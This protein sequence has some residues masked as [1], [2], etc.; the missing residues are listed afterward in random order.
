MSLHRIFSSLAHCSVFVGRLTLAVL[1]VSPMAFHAEAAGAAVVQV[2]ANTGKVDCGTYG[3]GI[4][5]GD[6]V[7]LTGRAR[8]AIS[9]SN[10]RGSA[11]SPIV[12][13]N[14]VSESGPL[15]VSQSGDGFLSQCVD[16][17]NVVIDGTGK[18]AGAPAGA[19][20]A[21]LEDGEW[22]LGTRQCGIVF[23]CTSGSPQS[24]LRLG[25]DSKFVIIKGV[26]VDGNLPTCN[27]GI[28]IS[29]N[30]HKYVGKG[31]RVARRY[32]TAQ[33]LRT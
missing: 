7:I 18:W 21:A 4:R 2:P 5:P 20:G 25:G 29:V 26:E 13:R 19:C 6:T 14:D 12:I 30:D 11:S 8:G 23:K 32:S 9:F 3:G 31:W 10:C 1:F 24:S 33:Q 22:K 27:A 15:V 28:G 16:C 17:E